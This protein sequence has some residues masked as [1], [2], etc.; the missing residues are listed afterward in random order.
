M[1]CDIHLYVEYRRAS[2]GYPGWNGFG[3][4]INPGRHYGIFAKLCDVRNWDDSGIIPID[5]PRG[6]PADITWAAD[7]DNKLFIT[8]TPDES[9]CCTK[10]Q[11]DRWIA[12]CSSVKVGNNYVTHPDWHSHSWCTAKE[13]DEVL[14]DPKIQFNPDHE[15]EW[16]ALNDLLKSFVRQGRET[17]IVF[18]FDN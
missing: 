13:L 14:M 5:Q 16:I 2:D 8:D 17:R 3:G 11:A 15:P 1:G 4:R 18:W 12:S 7:G 10:D 9:G 6:L